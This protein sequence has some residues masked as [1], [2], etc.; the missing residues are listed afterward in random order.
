MLL[1][2]LGFIFSITVGY[3]LAATLFDRHEATGRAFIPLVLVSLL[4]TLINFYLL[5]QPMGMRHAM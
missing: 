1:I 4:F 5:T 3:R 2:L